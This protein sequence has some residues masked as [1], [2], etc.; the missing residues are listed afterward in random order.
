[1][2]YYVSW[3]PMAGE[4]TYTNCFS[5]EAERNKFAAGLPRRAVVH[6]WENKVYNT[7]NNEEEQKR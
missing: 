5:S 7:E 2:L 6:I 1:M 3:S 4:A